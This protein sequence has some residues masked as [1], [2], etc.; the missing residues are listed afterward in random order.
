M[1]TLLVAFFIMLYSM[2]VM[3]NQKFQQVA[4]SVRSGFGGQTTGLGQGILSGG[5]A[6]TSMVDPTNIRPTKPTITA[7]VKLVNDLHTLILDKKLAGKVRLH[8]ET[9]GLVVTLVTDKVLF[10]K[11]QADIKAETL[12]LLKD[13][14]QILAKVPNPIRVEG[15]TCDLPVGKGRYA[16]NWD[17]S[18]SRAVAVVR[19]AIE[20]GLLP[21]N[22]LSAAGYADSKPV[23]PNDSEIHRSM[24]RRVDI[25]VV[26][27]LS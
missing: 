12:P 21:S 6:P 8:Q 1:I 16:S 15:H 19:Y 9:R 24:N 13:V 5:V 26:R 27:D 7:R 11:G 18:T 3:N 23:V 25:V 17:L 20:K 14:L 4:V 2:S 22:R 10:Q